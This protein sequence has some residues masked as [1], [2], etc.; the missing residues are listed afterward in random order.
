MDVSSQGAQRRSS[1]LNAAPSSDG[2]VTLGIA[3]VI[4]CLRRFESSRLGPL[5]EPSLLGG[6]LFALRGHLHRLRAPGPRRLSPHCPRS[7][8]LVALCRLASVS[9]E[10]SRFAGEGLWAWLRVRNGCVG[11]QIGPPPLLLSRSRFRSR[12]SVIG[13]L[14]GRRRLGV[15]C[16]GDAHA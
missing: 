8:A 10:A 5:G 13:S 1:A 15:E 6:E 4:L 7:V 14:R 2:K 9:V 12:T 16:R 3:R 11:R